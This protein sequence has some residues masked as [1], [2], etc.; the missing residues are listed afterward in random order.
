V[1]E[2]LLSRLN[3]LAQVGESARAKLHGRDAGQLDGLAV[4]RLL[5]GVD[6]AAARLAKLVDELQ[7]TLFPT[8]DAGE[9]NGKSEEDRPAGRRRRRDPA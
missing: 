6:A 7:P 3:D 8:A 1:N 9:Q 2:K 5:V 4:A